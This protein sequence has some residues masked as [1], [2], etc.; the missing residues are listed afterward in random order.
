MNFTV[1]GVSDA[2][3][4]ARGMPRS[5]LSADQHAT[6]ACDSILISSNPRK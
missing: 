2:C 5:I 4:A 6:F 1:L 3:V